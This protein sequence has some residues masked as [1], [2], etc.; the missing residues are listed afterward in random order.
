M[1]T[2]CTICARGGSKGVPRKNVRMLW[3]KP[4]IAHTIEQAQACNL[5]DAIYVSTDDEEIAAIAREY[6]AIVP[7]LRPAELATSEAGK[8]PVIIHLVEHVETLGVDV[9]RVVDLD[10]TSPL[11]DVADITAAVAL[12]DTDT[13]T[14]ITAYP[15]DKNPYFNMVEA[16]EDGNIRLVKPSSDGVASRQ[17]APDVYAMNASIYVWHRD[18]LA[19][20]LW[21]GR[22]RLHEMPHERSVDIDSEIDFKLVELLMGETRKK[23]SENV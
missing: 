20:G 13:D 2:I 1:T 10:P 7:F 11:R 4:L 17:A 3:G 6:G 8:L 21:A 12:L 23:E 14:V 5:I 16:K 19:K 22:T 18:T 15:A 9:T